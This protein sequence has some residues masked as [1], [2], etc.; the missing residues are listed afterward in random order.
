MSYQRLGFFFFLVWIYHINTFPH[1]IKIHSMA[2]I[3]ADVLNALQGLLVA[4][5]S[6]D[7]STRTQ[8][9]ESLATRWIAQNPDMLLSGLAEQ[10]KN[11]ED[12]KVCDT[13]GKPKDTTGEDNLLMALLPAG[14]NLDS[15]FMSGLFLCLPFLSPLF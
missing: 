10:V 8:A 3:P 15:L 12:P 14:L 9:E 1:A 4:L 13:S 6:P 11:H 7:N 2:M 5:Q